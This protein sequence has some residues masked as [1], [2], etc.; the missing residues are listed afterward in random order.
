M[1]LRIIRVFNDEAIRQA[2]QR[3]GSRKVLGHHSV[4]E[5]DGPEEVK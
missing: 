2:G 3:L 1:G 5:V 4:H